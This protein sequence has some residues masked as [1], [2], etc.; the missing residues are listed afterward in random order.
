[1]VSKEK[2]R[3]LC[4]AF[5]TI[6]FTFIF[7]VVDAYICV[8]GFFPLNQLGED[9][10]AAIRYW[11]IVMPI[12]T[13]LFAGGIGLGAWYGDYKT[14]REDVIGTILLIVTPFILIWCGIMDLFSCA[15]MDYMYTGI[16][17]YC[18]REAWWISRDWWW[19]RDPFHLGFG[20]SLPSWISAFLKSPMT[21]VW[22]VVAGAVIG[23]FLVSAL[24]ILY[25]KKA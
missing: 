17:G 3:M 16:F 1:M 11:W 15:V 20:W 14:G 25:L 8:K 12:L 19:M 13:G 6:A 4:L 9:P 2:R 23:V 7:Y 5:L 22:H 24:W 10:D 21:S 18:W